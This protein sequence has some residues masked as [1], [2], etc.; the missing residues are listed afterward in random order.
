MIEREGTGRES[1]GQ[2]AAKSQILALAGAVRRPD[3][4]DRTDQAKPQED[5]A[6]LRLLKGG[7]RTVTG[8]MGKRRPD[9]FQLGTATATIGIRGTDFVVRV[10]TDDCT[11]DTKAAAGTEPVRANGI[12]IFRFECGRIAEIWSEM[13]AVG[14]MEQLATAAAETTP[15]P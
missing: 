11:A 1:P 13:D 4:C 8:L 12:N 3:K 15:A 7:L 10:C 9:A 5:G 14:L 6:L 2:S